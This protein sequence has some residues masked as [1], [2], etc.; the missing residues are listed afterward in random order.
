MDAGEDSF[1][2]KL[3]GCS[4]DGDLADQ[5]LRLNHEW[6]PID[7]NIRCSSLKVRPSFPGSVGISS[8][9]LFHLWAL[10]IVPAN[11]LHAHGY[12]EERPVKSKAYEQ[13]LALDAQGG[14]NDDQG[15]FV[16]S[17]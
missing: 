17:G 1:S 15:P 6:T 8:W 5:F 3:D 14:R 16:V 11:T 12:C 10:I 13:P 2:S 7:T 9:R 4:S